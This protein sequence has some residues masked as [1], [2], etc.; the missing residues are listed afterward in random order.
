MKVW[1]TA[2][3]SSVLN[4][5]L[6]PTPST[7]VQPQHPTR[8]LSTLLETERRYGTTTERDPTQ[9]RHDYH[10][11]SK[12]SYFVLV[13]DIRQELA[14][15][16]AHEYTI[17]RTKDGEEKGSWPVPYCHP[18][19]RGPFMEYNEREEQ[20]REK[21][22]R[23]EREREEERAIELK[24][25]KMRQRQQ[26]RKNDLRRSVSMSNLQRQALEKE[27]ALQDGDSFDQLNIGQSTVA[28]SGYLGSTATSGY[29]AASGNSV[30]VTSN[31]GTTSTMGLG[32]SYMG[33]SS[34]PAPLRERLQNQVVTSRRVSA[35]D[36]VR[37]SGV[38]G[39]KAPGGSVSLEA[40]AS[41]AMMPP[42][43][44]IPD[45]VRMLKKSKSTNTLRLPKRD[46][47]SKPGYCESCRAKFEDFKAVSCLF[48]VD[49][50]RV[51]LK[52]SAMNTARSR[53]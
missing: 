45:R 14:T 9:K 50:G 12:N 20:R 1:E 46:E 36:R 31:Y 49:Y 33:A 53:P 41:S 44:D 2:K 13:E 6:V 3:L 29:V 19:A 15:I 21:Q 25:L 8:T 26:A 43:V 10:Y 52:V 39:G 30:R 16:A 40:S 18:L 11:F 22:E 27:L 23:I 48:V 38:D 34:L 4:R 42:P 32:S 24:R 28:P 37:N 51:V 47:K 7:T 17:T 5:C 35:L